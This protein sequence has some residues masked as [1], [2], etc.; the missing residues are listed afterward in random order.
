MATQLRIIFNFS[1]QLQGYTSVLILLNSVA[2]AGKYILCCIN[3]FILSLRLNTFIWPIHL[4]IS[5]FQLKFR[6]YKALN[7]GILNSLLSERSLNSQA[8]WDEHIQTLTERIIWNLIGGIFK[9]ETCNFGGYWRI[10]LCIC[11]FISR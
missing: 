5:R 1:L 10:Y 8:R 9:L 6:G 4:N 2:D 3:F 11:R 7:M